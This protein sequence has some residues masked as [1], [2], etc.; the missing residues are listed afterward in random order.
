[1]QFHYQAQRTLGALRRWFFAQCLD[2]LLVSAL[3]LASLRWLHVPW[4]WFWA[5]VAGALQF[6]PHFGPPLA[7]LGPALA[8]LVSGAPLGR[9]L[10]LLGA[11]A[12]IAALD[13]LALQ[14]LLMHRANRVPLWASVLMP[15]LLGIVLPFWGV[16]L[17]PPLLA[18]I[19]AHRAVT[20]REAPTAVAEQKFTSNDPGVVLPPEKPRNGRGSGGN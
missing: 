13:A 1:M 9:W 10:Q 8:M 2:S 3:W 15:V 5:L 19:Y 20:A 7:L 18:V 17:A 11:Y 16:L 12:V 14:P 6:I 4:P